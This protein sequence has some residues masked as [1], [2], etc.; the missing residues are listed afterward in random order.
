[1]SQVRSARALKGWLDFEED[2]PTNG[3]GTA[4]TY[5]KISSG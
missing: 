2:I 3:N 1:M 5:P 4:I